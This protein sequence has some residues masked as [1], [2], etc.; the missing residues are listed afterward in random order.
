METLQPKDWPRPKGYSNGIVAQGR[1]VVLAGQVGWDANET[2]VGEDLVA[3]L[4]QCFLNIRTLL[5]AAGAGPEHLVRLT[6][7]I[8]DADEY[9]ARLTEIGDAYR[10]VFGKVFPAMSVIAVK[11]FIEPGAK[12]E[13]EATAVI[14]D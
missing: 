1:L 6:W 7:F 9:Q 14:P 11:G 8:A 10:G 3:Q 5:N 2:L 12:A 4:R 13:I